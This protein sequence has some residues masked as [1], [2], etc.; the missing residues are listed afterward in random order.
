MQIL[1]TNHCTEV[2]TLLEKLEEGLK[3]LKR[4]ATPKE[5][6]QCQLTG[7]LRAPR[8]KTTNIW[9]VNK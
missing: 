3:E 7:P 6:Q 9:N 1:T 2:R 5:E 4:I 8:G